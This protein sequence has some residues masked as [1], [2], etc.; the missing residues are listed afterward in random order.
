MRVLFY[1]PDRKQVHQF[2][3]G[4]DRRF[5]GLPF[6]EKQHQANVDAVRATLEEC[7]QKVARVKAE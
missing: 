2:V 4:T 1:T 5:S 3:W 6:L 7:L